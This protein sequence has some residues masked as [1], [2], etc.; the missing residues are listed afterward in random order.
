MIFPYY[1]EI[2]KLDSE[3]KL[4]WKNDYIVLDVRE[5]VF[6]QIRVTGFPSSSTV[7]HVLSCTTSKISEIVIEKHEK[8]PKYEITFL[9][10]CDPEKM[11]VILKEAYR[12]NSRS[13]GGSE[14]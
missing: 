3:N 9:D 12:N 6:D 4:Q 1:A 10:F 14:Q 13:I 7:Y 11:K 2:K 5:A 8:H